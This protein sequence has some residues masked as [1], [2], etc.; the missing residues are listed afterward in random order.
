MWEMDY[1]DNTKIKKV[2]HGTPSLRI[3]SSHGSAP[4]SKNVAQWWLKGWTDC[5]RGAT[6]Q[7]GVRSWKASRSGKFVSDN[8]YG[9]RHLIDRWNMNLD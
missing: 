7:K 1:S 2:A 5:G 4:G 8:G 9:T 3:I 6:G